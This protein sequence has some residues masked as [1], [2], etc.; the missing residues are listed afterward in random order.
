MDKSSR[1]D[2]PVSEQIA[3]WDAWNGAAKRHERL[4]TASARQWQRLEQR[5]RALQR[6]D[7]AI[8]DVGCGSGWTCQRLLPFGTVTGTDLS[9]KTIETA[10]ERVPGAKFIA[11]NLFDV[12]LPLGAFDVAVSLEVLAHVADQPALVRRLA[13]LLADGGRLFLATQNR[14]VLE[15]WSQIGSPIPG[16][17]RRWV[18]HRTL[19]GLLDPC[20][21][22]IEI[23]S[24][25]PVG[26]R[27]L[28][29][30]LN[31]V[32]LNRLAAT[33]FS[34]QAIE[35]WKERRMLGHT[36]LAWARKR[37]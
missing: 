4:G 13:D 7:L 9:P 10:A 14:P 37:S 22:D 35:G 6:T 21:I 12:P 5:L 15:R 11:G 25:Y 17:I 16:T 2:I 8:V 23:E 3:S 33:I 27:G 29:R 26:D 30:I 31:S 32:K 1:L 36:L 34:E 19:R 24:V 20:F 18:D 28:L